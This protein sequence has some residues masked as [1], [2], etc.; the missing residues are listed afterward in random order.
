M[1]TITQMQRGSIHDGSCPNFQGALELVGRR[2]TGSII[3]AAAQGARRFGEYRGLIDGI[4]DRLLAQR[5]K[6]LEASGLLARTVVPSTPVQILY[7]LTPDG[8]SLVD[9]LR[10][11]AHWSAQRSV[12]NSG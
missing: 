11:L 6:E 7:D 1:S 9:A 8:R 5:L 4:S 12:R 3:E 2:W 10:P